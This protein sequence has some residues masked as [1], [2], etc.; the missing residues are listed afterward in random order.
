MERTIAE[1]HS[2]F[3]HAG[4]CIRIAEPKSNGDGGLVRI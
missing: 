1:K 4:V 3:I 2:T